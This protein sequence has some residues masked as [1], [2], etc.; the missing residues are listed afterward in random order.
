MTTYRTNARGCPADRLSLR[1]PV[2]WKI[3]QAPDDPR[4]ALVTLFFRDHGGPVPD[5]HVDACE[6]M[7][8]GRPVFGSLRH[9]TEYFEWRDGRLA[10]AG[11][12]RRPDG[13]PEALEWTSRRRPTG[14]ICRPDEFARALRARTDA[15]QRC[16]GRALADQP[17]LEGRL[18]VRCHVGPDGRVDSVETVRDDLDSK[19]LRRCIVETVQKISVTPPRAGD[20]CSFVYPFD[21]APDPPPDTASTRSPR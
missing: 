19:P 20:H 4:P 14:E 12:T 11:A 17:K 7:A 10:F 3:W 5:D 21:F 18:S 16:Y 2:G 13:A 15:I 1:Y 8:D 6:A 9:V